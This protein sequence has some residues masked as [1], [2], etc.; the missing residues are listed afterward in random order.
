M[1]FQ[2]KITWAGL[3]TALVVY[4]FYF[5]KVLSEAADTPVADVDYQWFL[6]GTIVVSVVIMIV[7]SIVVAISDPKQVDNEDERDKSIARRAGHIA[8]IAL[9]VGVLAPLAMAMFE[10]ETF[11]I[12]Q[13]ILAALVLSQIV[14]GGA[15]IVFYRRGF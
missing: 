14:E 7:A 2:E 13:A 8:G 10:F 15:K 3:G 12:A 9:G 6:V 5:V 1:S 11:W 4:A